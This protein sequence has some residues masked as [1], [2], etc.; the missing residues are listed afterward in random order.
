VSITQQNISLIQPVGSVT[1]TQIGNT[2]KLLNQNEV[3]LLADLKF[4]MQRADHA[5]R[6]ALIRDERFVGIILKLI[7]WGFPIDQG[8]KVPQNRFANSSAKM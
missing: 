4:R 8:E 7:E 1:I 2:M 6:V 5:G 3:D